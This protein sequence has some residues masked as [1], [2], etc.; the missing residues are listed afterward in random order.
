[1]AVINSCR[2]KD[3]KLMHLLRGIFFVVAHFNIYV[4]ATHVPGVENVAADALS[5]NSLST[6]LQEVPNAE[7]Q[8][9]QIPQALVDMTVWEQPNWTSERWGQLFSAFCKQG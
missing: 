2:A 5:R 1:M 3:E 9:T 8:P 4:H 6:F 7:A